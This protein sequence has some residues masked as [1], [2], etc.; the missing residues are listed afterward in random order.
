MGITGTWEGYVTSPLYLFNYNTFGGGQTGVSIT[1][2]GSS[3]CIEDNKIKL[4][5]ATSPTGIAVFDNMVSF[6]GYN[7]LNVVGY[8]TRDYARADCILT[9]T[10]GA[11]VANFTVC[12]NKNTAIT[13]KL[14][15]S[16]ITQSCELSIIPQDYYTDTDMSSTVYVC[17]VYLSTT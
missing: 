7:Y 11:E 16:A 17:Q 8:A 6:T 5:S 3:N 2:S 12:R 14:D 9:A 4:T 13:S 10:G 15:V 1:G